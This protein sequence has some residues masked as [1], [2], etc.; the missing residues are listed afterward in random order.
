MVRL[1]L[2]GSS[3]TAGFVSNYRVHL[4]LLGLSQTAWFVLNCRVLLKLQGSSQTAGFVSNYR[5]HLE[6]QGLS[7][8]SSCMKPTPTSLA[9]HFSFSLYQV[10]VS[11]LSYTLPPCV[12]SSCIAHARLRNHSNISPLA[13]GTHLKLRVSAN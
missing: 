10:H 13:L 8:T 6:L 4:E 1:E 3:R 11:C 12:N 9:A 7:Q 5:V 2:Q